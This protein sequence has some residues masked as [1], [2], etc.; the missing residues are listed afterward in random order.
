MPVTQEQLDNVALSTA[1]YDL[2][3]QRLGREPNTV[4]LGLFG[5]MWSEHCGYKHSK[6]LLRLLP[7]TSDRLLVEPGKENAGVI[8]IGN[9]KAVVAKVESHN[10]PSA[11]E[12]FQGAAT[13]VGG[14]VRDI[15]AMGA[16]PIALLNSLRFGSIDEPLSASL[17]KGAVS[18]ISWYGNCIG[19]PDVGGEISFANCYSQNP[20]VNAMCVGIV[21]VDKLTYA[22]ASGIGN[23]MFLIGSQ[24][25]RDGIHGASGLASRTFEDDRELRPTVQV[26]NPFL[27]KVLIEACLEI[28]SKGIL[29]GMQDLGA[30]GL[31]SSV[32]ECAS[33]GEVGIDLDL[34]K[35]PLRE[36][37]MNAYDI[38]LSES[39][40]RMLL[41][42]SEKDEQ[43]IIDTCD[44]WDLDYAHI[45]T[46]TDTNRIEIWL[47]GTKEA[48]LPIDILTD[49][50]LYTLNGS[51][52]PEA[53]AFAA[54][55]LS[56]LSLPTINIR[57]A[58]LSML[59][60]PDIASKE[61]VYRQY[62][63]MV[64]TNTVIPPGADAAVIRVT[65]SELGIAVATDG[66]GRYCE[67]DPFHGGA[68]AIAEATR[69]LVCVGA[70]P[71]ALSDCLN[72]GDPEK[73]EVAF[74]LEQ[75]IQGMRA[76]CLALDVPVISGNV[77]LYN[78]TRGEA[79]YPTPVIG[80][81]GLV[82]DINLALKPGFKQAGDLVL[83]LGSGSMD[84]DPQ[85]LAASL[86]LEELHN[87]SG[88]MLTIDL[89]LETKLQKTCLALIREELIESA[90][91]CSDGGLGV[92][93]AES[94]MPLSV[95]F[96]LETPLPE[97]W[98]AALF[99]E[100]Q[101]RII[102][103][104]RSEKLKDVAQAITQNQVPWMSLGHTTESGLQLGETSLTIP[105]IATAF[106][107]RFASS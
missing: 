103:S 39:Q 33:K 97:R 58:L 92:A 82:D 90:H 86:A 32:I 84:C 89:D 85:D 69:N 6:L 76:A 96:S 63:H 60:H 62:D 28:A 105:E 94:C 72:F 64:Q 99:S 100:T 18:G 19:V 14:I 57:E 88:R 51:Q 21:E 50:P 55:N 5:S 36:A 59:S 2:I 95:G 20:L 78:E 22:K 81:V 35:V 11:V 87:T 77:S 65:G 34:T 74:Q 7:N 101:S 38:M 106:L 102:I 1:E 30:A 83:L 31:T 66:N 43:T 47:N 16:R 12:P 70:E 26:G 91:D 53:K 46:V 104:V 73:P 29:V 61:W 52:S 49:P 40:E 75:C 37:G 3:L 25:G 15:F 45:G 93:L 24:T 9:G 71:V 54:T 23:K 41:I 68:I 79:V 10:H 98:D 27:E 107:S 80:S 4:E 13:G 8:D 67:A 42:V 48:D 56:S 44:K 17:F